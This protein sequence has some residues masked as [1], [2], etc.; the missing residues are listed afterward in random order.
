MIV[1]GKHIQREL[2]QALRERVTQGGRRIVLTIVIAHETLAIRKFVE[3]KQRFGREVGVEV[4][5][6]V[7]PA[8]NQSTEKL[9]QLLLHT[10]R[11]SDGIV[12]QLPLPHNIEL[13]PILKLFPLSHD[14]DV[15]GET[16]F[17]Q[18]KEK[19]LPFLPP[20]VGAFAEVLHKHGYQLAGRK[21]VVVGEGR[22][23]GEPAAVWARNM[24]GQVTVVN[25]Y[26]PDVGAAT[27]DA[28]VIISGAGAPSLITPDMVKDGA[29][30]LDAGT[31][32]SEGVLTGDID[33][34]CAD[35]AALYT[36]TPGGIGPI[37]VAKVFENLVM[38]HG[39]THRNVN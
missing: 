12:L 10:T 26:T 34:G 7:L 24:G 31:S 38:L 1:D 2:K 9:L 36:P 6:E 23:V 8:L 27:R 17:Q 28:D 33:P 19:T 25:V 4:E 37:T 18:F 32:E 16:T 13:A 39:L 30:L 15:L 29:I 14:V 21:V 11:H 3:L 5:V 22:L 35:K 20:V